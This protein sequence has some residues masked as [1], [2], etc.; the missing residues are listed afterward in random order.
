MDAKFLHVFERGFYRNCKKTGDF[1]ERVKLTK[2]LTPKRVALLGEIESYADSDYFNSA[3]NDEPKRCIKESARKWDSADISEYT[4]IS[5]IRHAVTS[6][7]GSDTGNNTVATASM[8]CEAQVK[9]Q[10]FPRSRLMNGSL[11]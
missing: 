10:S 1:S 4:D 11:L 7:S 2:M 3:R 6:P 8:F 9:K 5:K